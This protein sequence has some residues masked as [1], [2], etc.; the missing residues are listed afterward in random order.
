VTNE[1]LD[2]AIDTACR[3]CSTYYGRGEVGE[4]MLAHLKKLLAELERRLNEEKGQ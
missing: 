1:E 2:K 3:H 4:T